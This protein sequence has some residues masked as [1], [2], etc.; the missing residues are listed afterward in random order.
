MQCWVVVRKQACHGVC[1]WQ[2]SFSLEHDVSCG[3]LDNLY[4]V[5][6]RLWFSGLRSTFFYYYERNAVGLFCCFPV[7]FNILMLSPPLYCINIIMSHWILKVESFSIP[8]INPFWSQYAVFFLCCWFGY[9]AFQEILRLNSLGVFACDFHS[10]WC[11]LPWWEGDT[12]FAEWVTSFPSPLYILRESL[13]GLFINI[14]LMVGDTHK[15]TPLVLAFS[16]LRAFNDLSSDLPCLPISFSILLG[17]VPRF[18]LIPVAHLSLVVSLL[19][20][21]QPPRFYH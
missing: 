3:L 5:R 19:H 8:E 13:W 17:P 1:S 10:V 7:S 9:L 2:S 14:H 18:L 16:K 4:R 15:W 6:K 20:L 11:V 21:L 12:G